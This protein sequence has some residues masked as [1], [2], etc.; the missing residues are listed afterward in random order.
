METAQDL[1]VTW[2]TAWLSSWWGLISSQNFSG[3]PLFLLFLILQ[4]Y[5]TWWKAWFCLV[6]NLHIGVTSSPKTISSRGSTSLES[7]S[8]P[9]QGKCKVITIL[10]TSNE[11][12]YLCQL[13]SCT[14][15]AETGLGGLINAEYSGIVTS[16]SLLTMLLFIQPRMLLASFAIR[17]YCSFMLPTMTPRTFSAD[18]VTSH[19]T[20]RL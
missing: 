12:S 19:T 16:F 7:L 3:F 15:G 1:W 10:V 18:T 20:P 8:L 4:A 6:D 9:L 2:S 11:I 17:A 5:I 13:L 14:R